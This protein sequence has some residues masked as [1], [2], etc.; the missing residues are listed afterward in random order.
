MKNFN[1]LNSKLILI[2]LLLASIVATVYLLQIV[3]NFLSQFSWLFIVLIYAYLVYIIISPID[4]LLQRF[5]ISKNLSLMF[6]FL[7][8]F[9]ILT[10]LIFFVNPLVSQE[11]TVL[12]NK[13][14]SLD[15]NNTFDGIITNVAQLLKSDP[16]TFKEELLNNIK[17]LASGFVSNTVNLFG[18][19][20]VTTV[21][22]ILALIFG[23]F[24]V[25]DGK[26]WFEGFLKL[27]P[28]DFRSEVKIIGEYFNVSAI[29]FI[30]VQVLM[31]LIYGILN[32][33]IMSLLNIDFSLSASIIAF[34]TFIIPGIGP[35]LSILIPI[36]VT[37]LFSPD[38][39][40]LIVILLL[41]VQQILLN[42]LIPKL[43]GDKVGVHPIVILLSIL[44]GV[45]LF[46][47]MGAFISIPLVAVF[48]NVA[49]K[50]VKKIQ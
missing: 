38:R 31:A 50:Y 4:R 7:S 45:Q 14:K 10:L 20:L 12:S 32:Y 5:N 39:L 47:V 1:I 2:P 42:I 13:L 21:Q 35:V 30:S 3:F 17:N 11:L 41:I 23:Y 24:F 46:G 43:Y 40:L 48:V 26:K 27:I 36:F 6:S 33:I 22:I 44:V 25:K 34:L 37:A 28:E 15:L 16:V 9:L 29:S 19:V 49:E 18:N 8:L